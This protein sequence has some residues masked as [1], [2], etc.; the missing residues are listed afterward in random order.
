MRTIKPLK[1]DEIIV[2]TRKR[3]IRNIEPP[4]QSIKFIALLNPITVYQDRI[5]LA[6]SRNLS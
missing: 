5:L 4:K 6:D 2:L 3:Q 1:I